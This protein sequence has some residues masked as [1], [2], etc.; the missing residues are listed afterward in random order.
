M[1][2]GLTA[3]SAAQIVVSGLADD[4]QAT[5]AGVDLRAL[6]QN[7][8]RVRVV[9]AS[10]DL[11][12]IDVSVAAGAAPFPGVAFRSSAGCVVFFGGTYGVQL[13]G[14]GEKTLLFQG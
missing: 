9:H 12:N 11:E 4:V 10:P 1:T 7:Q 6:P 14:G 8:A 3:G 13:R 5:I 2:R